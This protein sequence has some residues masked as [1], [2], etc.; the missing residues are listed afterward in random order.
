MRHLMLAASA[1][2]VGFSCHPFDPGSCGPAE[3]LASGTYLSRGDGTWNAPPPPFPHDN[4]QPKTLRLELEAGRLVITDLR[5]D[6]QEVVETWRPKPNQWDWP[7][8]AGTH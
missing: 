1:L 5:D 4:K 6:G 2:L 7:T 8:D 3:P